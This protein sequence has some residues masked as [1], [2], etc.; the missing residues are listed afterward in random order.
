MHT[1]LGF[2]QSV[3]KR[4]PPNVALSKVRQPSECIQLK[5]LT[6]KLHDRDTISR[7]RIVVAHEV[8]STPSRS[9]TSSDPE[10]APHITFALYHGPLSL[11]LVSL[12]RSLPLA[13]QSTSSSK[14]SF[15]NNL[16]VWFSTAAC[17]SGD[18]NDEAEKNDP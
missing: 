4:F 15:L 6:I 10:I 9:Y 13:L 1:A 18:R 5:L 3:S 14:C 11:L 7:S 2:L 12:V 17:V 16:S 8:R